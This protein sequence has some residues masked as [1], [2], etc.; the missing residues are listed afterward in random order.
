VLHSAF[1]IE[2]RLWG[3]SVIGYHLLNIL[4]HAACAWL[5][6]R[7]LH[8]LAVPGALLAAA[9]FALHPVQVESVAWMAEQKNTLSTLFYLAAGLAYVEFHDSRRRSTYLIACG[10][11]V[12]G[13]LTKTVVATLPI[14]LLIIAWWRHGTLRWRRDLVPLVP[15]IGIGAVAGLLTAWIERNALGAEGAPFALTL[16]QRTL[17][18]GRVILFYV[19]KLLW[20]A[21]LLFNYPRW[22]IL[23][24]DRWQYLPIAL[25]TL[26][27]VLGWRLRHRTRAPLAAMLFFVVTLG[28][29]LGFVNVY[30]FAFSFV[31][32]HFQYVASLGPIVAAAAALT[33]AVA[34]LAPTAR[35]WIVP[36]GSALLLGTLAVL[37][38][39][40]SAQY[41]DPETLYERT[42]AGNPACYLC[43][44]NLG[45]LAFQAG[46][47]DEAMAR[48][49]AAVQIAPES[50][51]AQS[52][53]AN[54]L[55]ERGAIAEGIDHYR[56][57][58][59]AA[60]RSVITRTNLGVT[61]VRAG[62]LA[63]AAEQFEVAL[64]I[65]PEYAPARRNLSILRSLPQ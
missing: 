2:H 37:T 3:D 64:R 40:Q 31:A 9:I 48:F 26:L 15:W 22:Q 65:M 1:W 44:N 25:V 4:L 49:T 34:R 12:L 27:L 10:F 8:R 39:R 55:V 14:A 41:R 33:L 36:M 57:A 53:L 30:P 11:F 51:E 47:A 61:L 18:A 63:E 19:G 5:V 52:N 32:D 13:L 50:A 56:L 17:L 16:V 43:L 46:R 42:L 54:V 58:L 24:T 21:D 45:L 6:W 7:M 20:P 35:R 38:W 62:R 60:P 23:P 28:P 29:A 59:A